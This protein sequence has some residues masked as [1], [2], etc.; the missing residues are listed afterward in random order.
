MQRT[1]Y[2]S[3]PENEVGRRVGIGVAEVEANEPDSVRVRFP[4]R[5]SCSAI[6]LTAASCPDSSATAGR[7][8]KI[9]TAGIP[10]PAAY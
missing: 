7:G 2:K 4:A 6:A 1:T 8:M 5:G 3:E 10:G 9:L